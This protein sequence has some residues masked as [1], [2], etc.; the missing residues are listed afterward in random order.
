MEIFNRN[1]DNLRISINPDY[2]IVHNFE[3]GENDYVSNREI[4]NTKFF[5]SVYNY[6]YTGATGPTGPRCIYSADSYTGP[7]A[8]RINEEYLTSED[9]PK[10]FCM[11][12]NFQQRVGSS[13]SDYQNNDNVDYD[14]LYENLLRVLGKFDGHFLKTSKPQKKTAPD[15]TK[16]REEF[17]DRVVQISD[18]NAEIEKSYDDAIQKLKDLSVLNQNTFIRKPKFEKIPDNFYE[19]KEYTDTTDAYIKIYCHCKTD[20]YKALVGCGIL[21]RSMNHGQIRSMKYK[22]FMK[23]SESTVYPIKD[24]NFTADVPTYGCSG[25]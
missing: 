19:T 23:R 22:K 3:T 20:I 15:Y 9:L 24:C 18:R 21:M 25:C 10:I 1:Y 2:T 5:D 13:S 12:I 17:R 16:L 14:S 6:Q 11:T 7:T 8:D 4:G